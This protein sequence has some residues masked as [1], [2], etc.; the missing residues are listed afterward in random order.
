[1]RPLYGMPKPSPMPDI[2]P[3]RPALD[4][5][6]DAVELA[7]QAWNRQQLDGALGLVD[8]HRL[9]V[10]RSLA[11][12]TPPPVPREPDEGDYDLGLDGRPN[13]DRP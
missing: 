13:R 4:D 1:M 9:R 2:R 11:Q 6:R 3:A 8:F 10:S 7:R 12:A 5:L